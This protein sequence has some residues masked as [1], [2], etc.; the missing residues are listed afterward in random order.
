MENSVVELNNAVSARAPR[1]LPAS[2]ASA[3][4]PKPNKTRKLLRF[5]EDAVLPTL[6]L[7]KPAICCW[8]AEEVDLLCDDLLTKH[9]AGTLGPLG[10]DV[11]WPSHSGPGKCHCRSQRYSS[12]RAATSL[13][14]ICQPE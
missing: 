10:F 11:E 1:K 2:F 9:F 5:G 6:T 7:Q 12:L 4:P 3:P 14:S 8:H 13:C